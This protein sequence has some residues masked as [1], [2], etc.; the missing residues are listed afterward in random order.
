L[1]VKQKLKARE[2]ALPGDR[3]H[4]LLAEGLGGGLFFSA[5]AIEERQPTVHQHSSKA[6]A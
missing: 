6:A 5:S 2:A 3:W 4:D 1:S